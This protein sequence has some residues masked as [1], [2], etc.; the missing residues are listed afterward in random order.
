VFSEQKTKELVDLINDYLKNSDSEAVIEL[1][2]ASANPNAENHKSFMILHWVVWYGNFDLLNIL[3]E[4][5]ADMNA[6]DEKGLILLHWAT[7][8]DNFYFVMA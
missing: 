2:P 5:K 4:K 6:R 7:F 8:S 3:I 1:L